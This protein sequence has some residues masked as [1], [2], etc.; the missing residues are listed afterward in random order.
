M[1][2]M[3]VY[4]KLHFISVECFSVSSRRVSRQFLD[5]RTLR[6]PPPLTPQSPRFQPILR[7]LQLWSAPV[8]AVPSPS[9]PLL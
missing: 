1:T 8:A 2:K 5:P 7:P 4:W 6:P 3:T 9:L